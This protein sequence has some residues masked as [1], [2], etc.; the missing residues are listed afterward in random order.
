MFVSRTPQLAVLEVLGHLS[1]VKLGDAMALSQLRGL[2][3][4]TFTEVVWDWDRRPQRYL[5]KHL[6]DQVLRL[7]KAAPRI[8]WVLRSI[9]ELV[10]WHSC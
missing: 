7:Q 9:P 5:P 10:S 2:R 1:R 8:K 3:E 4:V 6:A